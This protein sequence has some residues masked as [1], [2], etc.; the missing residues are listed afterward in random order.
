M[1]LFMSDN[2]PYA[3][4][5]RV[6]LREIGRADNIEEISVNPRDPAT[7]F[8]NINPVGK[9]PALSLDDGVT[10]VES[11]L[12]CRYLDVRLADGVMHKPVDGDANRLRILGLAQGILDKGMVARVEKQREGGPDQ[13]DFVKFHQAAVGR[14]LDALE[15]TAPDTV[16]APDMADIAAICAADWVDFRHPELDI[17]ATRPRLAAWVSALNARPAFAAT[18]PG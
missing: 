10:I 18:R 14:A 11:D 9:I 13:D 17:L 1:K 4:K 15:D 6:M 5:V 7:G 3:R 2:S 8:W 16:S 12:V